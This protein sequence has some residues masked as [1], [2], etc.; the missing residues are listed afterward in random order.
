MDFLWNKNLQPPTFPPLEGDMHTDVLI[1]GGGMAG[2]LCAN[3]LAKA[4]V[5]YLL[6]EAKTIGQG[7]TKGTTAVLTPQHGTL[8]QD[9]I[10]KFGSNKAKQYLAA[11]MTAARQ[12]RQLAQTVACDY[13][14]C[15]SIMYSLKNREMMEMEVKAVQSLGFDARFTT[16]VPLSLPIAGAVEFPDMAQFHPLKFLY[17]I[18]QGLNI[19]EHT[20]VRKLQGTA[21]ITHR[22]RI[23]AKKVIVATHFP[24]INRHGL[25]FMKL[26]QRR[27]YVIAY[28]YGPELTCTLADQDENG[29]YLRN[30]RDL[31]L[32]GGGGHR[33]GKPGGGYQ[34]IRDFA[35]QQFPQAQEAL[36]WSNQDCVTLDGVPYIGPYSSSLPH[37][38]TATGFNHWGMTTSMAAADILA[39]MV[40]GKDSPCSPVFAPTRSILR[41][42]LWI[43][44]GTTAANL[45]SPTTK[46]CT[47]LG[48]ALKWN[49]AEHS[50]DCPCHGSRFDQQ[51][52][53]ID[54]PAM[55][56][57]PTTCDGKRKK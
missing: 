5:P 25:Y 54:N 14:V 23:T 7:I 16:D 36:H 56:D 44:L 20:F 6:V 39:A 45:L 10:H 4:G 18:A 43:N 17:A 57:C 50:W 34:A 3:K 29:F 31:L 47:H 1:I 12:F 30:W 49:P 9:M 26:Y 21:A 15:P 33:T 51:G 28:R 40:Q 27:S 19:R 53:L 22:G 37:I 13:S 41:K 55:K 38:Y 52:Q 35:Q 11:N 42:Q 8:Y 48:C 32:I 24:F 46:R 2:I